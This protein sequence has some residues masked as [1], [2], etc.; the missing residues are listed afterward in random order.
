MTNRILIT[1]VTGFVGRQV[2]RHLAKQD[3]RVTAVVREGK[4]SMVENHSAIEAIIPV[5][6]LFSK[7]SEWWAQVLMGT[8]I[9]I[10]I[11]WYAEPGEY[12]RSPKN[13]DCLIGTLNMAKGSAIAGVKRFLGIGTCLEY[14]SSSA[15]LTIDSALNPLTPYASSK[16]AAYIALSR[17]LPSQSI[18]FLWCRLFYLFGEGE[19]KRRL[20]SYIRSKLAACEYAELTNGSKIRDYMDVGE[21]GEII[22]RAAFAKTTGAI[23][24]CSGTPISVQQLA[25]KIADE[26]GRRD[27]L[28]FNT[29]PNNFTDPP[30][31][32]GT[33]TKIC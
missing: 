3:V 26:F 7:S 21:A 8:D 30:I 5:P 32:I 4:Q 29:K 2:L 14:E 11:A 31:I 23:N 13:F 15:A 17:F 22:T 20:V 16:A 1:G 10:H 18:E 6:D 27:L 9:V 19:D 24:I 33:R 28:K 12:L 25:E